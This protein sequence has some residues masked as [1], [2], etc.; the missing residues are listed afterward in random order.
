M[1]QLRP[2]PNCFVGFVT[3]D[4]GLL[5]DSYLFCSEGKDLEEWIS[6]VLRQKVG[7]IKTLQIE[8]K[9]EIKIK[10]AFVGSPYRQ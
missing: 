1:P 9:A 5:E 10:V 2:D 8:S 4:F 7:P 6:K 3:N